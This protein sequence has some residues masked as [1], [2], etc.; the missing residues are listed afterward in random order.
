MSTSD[1]NTT[2]D[3]NEA[4][5]NEDDIEIT[6]KNGTTDNNVYGCTECSYKCSALPALKDHLRL[7]RKRK[8]KENGPVNVS[9]TR[10]GY[11]CSYPFQLETHVKNKHIPNVLFDTLCCGLCDF[12]CK[13][14]DAFTVHVKTHQKPPADPKRPNSYS[15]K[16]CDFKTENKKEF[17]KHKQLHLKSVGEQIF[18][19]SKCSYTSNR[20]DLVLLHSGIHYKSGTPDGCPAINKMRKYNLNRDERSA[21]IHEFYKNTQSGDIQFA[22]NERSGV[23][24]QSS[25][26]GNYES[27]EENEDGDDD[28][29]SKY[30]IYKCS[31]CNFTDADFQKVREHTQ[32]AHTK[33]KIYRCSECGYKAYDL[34]SIMNHK[35]FGCEEAEPEKTDKVFQCKKCLFL[36]PLHDNFLVHKCDEIL[37]QNV[38][39]MDDPTIIDH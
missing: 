9:C 14:K 11:V 16:L 26:D 7:H 12:T 21:L 8:S 17:T 38:P 6:D 10:C 36:T 23:L 30:T 29:S 15:C 34:D 35:C 1:K 25:N 20:K 3:E 32:S 19:C 4:D 37:A 33:E 31:E 22:Q 13:S 39:Q 28:E 18:K 2:A 27:N 24:P 5:C